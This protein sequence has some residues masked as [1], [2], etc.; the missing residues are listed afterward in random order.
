MT[1]K[2]AIVLDAFDQGGFMLRVYTKNDMGEQ[3]C[4]FSRA[5]DSFEKLF[6]VAEKVLGDDLRLD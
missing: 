6:S 3:E 5:G 1:P 4:V 2:V